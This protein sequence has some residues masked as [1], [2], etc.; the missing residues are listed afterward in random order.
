MDRAVLGK[1][2]ADFMDGVVIN[3]F[4]HIN[5]VFCIVVT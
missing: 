3:N 5:R 1:G 4:S 2:A